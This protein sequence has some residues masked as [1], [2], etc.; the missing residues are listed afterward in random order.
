MKKALVIAML[1]GGCA[2]V[3]DERYSDTLT[4]KYPTCEALDVGHAK[5]TQRIENKD[6]GRTGKNGAHVAALAASG[7]LGCLPCLI[8]F[9]RLR[10]F[11]TPARA[12]TWPSGNVSGT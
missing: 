9:L 12:R 10:S 7:A 11:T 1:L 4:Q 8:A 6:M 2:S 3:P 5:L